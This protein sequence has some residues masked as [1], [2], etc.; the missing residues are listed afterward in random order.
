MLFF[1]TF[2]RAVALFKVPVW[3]KM[4]SSA[5]GQAPGPGSAAEGSGSAGKGV[6]RAVRFADVARL[7]KAWAGGKVKALGLKAYEKLPKRAQVRERGFFL[8]GPG[9]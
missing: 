9:E 3:A 2:H 4:D 5:V 6:V 1:L 7:S 8:E